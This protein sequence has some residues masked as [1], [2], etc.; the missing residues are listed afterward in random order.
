MAM[1]P[2][3]ELDSFDLRLVSGGLLTA[4]VGL[5]LMFAAWRAGPP[6]WRAAR[7]LAALSATALAGGLAP[8]LWGEP[9]AHLLRDIVPAAGGFVDSLAQSL[10][11]SA[12]RPV[13]RDPDY[14]GERDDRARPWGALPASRSDS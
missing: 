11:P 2:I 9:A 13:L 10:V 3:A 8:P 14:A 6:Q 4:A 1:G 12:P 7:R 5:L